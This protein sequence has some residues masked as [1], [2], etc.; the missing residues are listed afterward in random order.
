MSSTN[1]VNKKRK[2]LMPFWCRDYPPLMYRLYGGINKKQRK[3]IRNIVK[4]R[5]HA[6]AYGSGISILKNFQGAV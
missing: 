1:Q 5:A 6:L 3:A 4:R 2:A